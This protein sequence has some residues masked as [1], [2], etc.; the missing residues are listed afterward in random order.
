MCS[1]ARHAC[2]QPCVSN[3]A[4]SWLPTEEFVAL[5][6]IKAGTKLRRRRNTRQNFR[7]PA[8][9]E[10]AGS[11][12]LQR[13]FRLL[14]SF[15]LMFAST[16][17]SL[18]VTLATRIRP[19]HRALPCGETRLHSFPSKRRST[20]VP[21]RGGMRPQ[22]SRVFHNYNASGYRAAF[23]SPSG[24]S[25]GA[26]FGGSFSLRAPLSPAAGGRCSAAL[27][28]RARFLVPFQGR[29]PA[30]CDGLNHRATTPLHS[31]LAFLTCT[32][33]F[34]P[35]INAIHTSRASGAPPHNASATRVLQCVT[36]PETAP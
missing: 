23:F 17:N 13:V 34:Y 30:A 2:R 28:H 7:P 15:A 3:K 20:G 24:P 4:P 25:E 26:R 12:K 22:L 8:H 31:F 9:Y 18:C 6:N 1:L 36:G 35:S 29:Q 14:F 21:L 32:L 19:S 10:C 33:L 11:L 16:M 27:R 5:A